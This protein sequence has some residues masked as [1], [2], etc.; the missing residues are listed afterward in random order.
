MLSASALGSLPISH[1]SHKSTSYN[2]FCGG[3]ENRDKNKWGGKKGVWAEK[4]RGVGMGTREEKIGDKRVM[5][6]CCTKIT[7]SLLA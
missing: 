5:N 1:A 6:F 2:C 4:V 3:G 7:T